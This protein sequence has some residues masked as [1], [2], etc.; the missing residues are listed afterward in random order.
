MVL[1]PLSESRSSMLKGAFSA[2]AFASPDDWD[3]ATENGCDPIS[4][5]LGM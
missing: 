4:A 2:K 3:Q 1:G 5:I